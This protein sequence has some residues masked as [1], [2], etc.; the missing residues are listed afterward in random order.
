MTAPRLPLSDLFHPVFSE[1]AALTVQVFQEL[2]HSFY[3]LVQWVNIFQLLEAEAL[4][5]PI[6][7]PDGIKIYK[8]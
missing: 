7:S 8:E 4:R 5:T 3:A 1:T 2:P 6:M